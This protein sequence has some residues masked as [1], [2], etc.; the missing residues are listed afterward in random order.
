MPRR[1]FRVV[2][3]FGEPLFPG[4]R[5]ASDKATA[6]ALNDRLAAALRRLAAEAGE[7]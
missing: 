2:V 6:D 5:L 7:P 3:R 4:E 1:A